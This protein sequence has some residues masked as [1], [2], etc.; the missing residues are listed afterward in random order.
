MLSMISIVIIS[1]FRKEAAV[2]R[3]IR[4]HKRTSA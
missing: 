2:E 4:D 1:C 3:F